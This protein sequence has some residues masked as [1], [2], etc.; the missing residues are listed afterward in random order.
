MQQNQRYLIYG[1]LSAGGLIVFTIISFIFGFTVS[2]PLALL[3]G[4]LTVIYKADWALGNQG[5]TVIG[6]VVLM[7]PAALLTA[8]MWIQIGG[9]PVVSWPVMNLYALVLPA[10]VFARARK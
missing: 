7:G 5:P 1:G 3:A 6:W 4:Q 9:A 2:L 8:G 10:A